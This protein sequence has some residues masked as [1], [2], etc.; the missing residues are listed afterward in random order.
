MHKNV[1]TCIPPY[2]QCTPVPGPVG[3]AQLLAFPPIDSTP[4]HRSTAHHSVP[5]RR[6]LAD[7]Q[8]APRRCPLPGAPADTPAGPCR[9]RAEP[10]TRPPVSLTL[11]I[12]I[13]RRRNPCSLAVRPVPWCTCGSST[14]CA[15]AC[16]AVCSSGGSSVQRPQAYRGRALQIGTAVTVQLRRGHHRQPC[17]KL[18]SRITMFRLHVYNGRLVWTSCSLPG[19]CR[20]HFLDDIARVSVT[21]GVCRVLC[22]LC[23]VEHVACS[24]PR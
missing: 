24:I 22:R 11:Y 21:H 19:R 23:L 15:H 4:A 18:L 2:I 17:S 10:A 3:P 1:S 20:G 7:V 9:G 14:I 13:H 5:T 12:Q 16:C 8:P 6:V